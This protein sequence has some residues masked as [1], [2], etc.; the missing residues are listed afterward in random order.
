MQRLLLPLASGSPSVV[1]ALGPGRCS[2]QEVGFVVVVFSRKFTYHA[3]S[4][5]LSFFK[6]F[7]LTVGVQRRLLEKMKA[8]S[9]QPVSVS[10]LH[11]G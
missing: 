11:K 8:V 10:L 7:V 2:F 9:S 5:F 4:H 3:Y 1:E 6:E